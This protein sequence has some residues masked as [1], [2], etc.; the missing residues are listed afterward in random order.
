[1]FL[2]QNLNFGICDGM[3][4]PVSLKGDGF[5]MCNEELTFRNTRTYAQV[6]LSAICHNGM[7]AKKLFSNQL[8]LSVLKADAYGHGI[9]GVIPAYE[10][11]SDWYAVATIEEALQ[12]RCQSKKPILL[13]GPVPEDQMVVAAQNDLTFTV[14]SYDYASRLSARMKSARMTAKCHLKIDTGLNRSGIRWRDS[15]KSLPVIRSVLKSE[16]LSFTGTYTHLACGEGQESWEI[17]NTAQQMKR[18]MEVCTA[19]EVEGMPVGIRHCCSTG[20]ALVNPEYRLDMVRLGMLPMGMSYSDESVVVLDLRPALTW[21]SFIA[22]IEIVNKGEPISYGCTYY[23]PRDMK[24]GIVTCGYADGYRRVYS[25]KSHVLVNGCKIPVVG[26]VAMDYTM[27]DL[28]DVDGVKVGD[29]V[30]LLGSD[31]HNSVTAMELS[32]YGESV[33]GEVTCV[34]SKRVPRIYTNAKE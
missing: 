10:T 34:I 6:D 5:K 11:F 22:Q 28:T 21:K 1:M 31:G 29:T 4:P 26:R 27:V 7:I 30:I 23:A 2:Q 24:I 3:I 19:M 8:I 18:F 33:S 14:G 15:K 20:G 17:A 12:I 13:F 9:P 32:A 25:N 16:C